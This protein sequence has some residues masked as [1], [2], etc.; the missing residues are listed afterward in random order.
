MQR[1]EIVGRQHG[2]D[3]GVRGIDEGGL[4]PDGD[5]FLEAPDF[6]LHVDRQKLLRG[7]ADAGALERL[8][9]LQS[10]AKCIPAW[11]DGREVVF[12]DRI[13]HGLPRRATRLVDELYGDAG[14]NGVRLADR[15]AHPRGEGL[16]RDGGRTEHAHRM[17]SSS[18]G[19][20]RCDVRLNSKVSSVD[21]LPYDGGIVSS[22]FRA[23]VRRRRPSLA[24]L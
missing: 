22:S 2:A 19:T 16:S 13:R 9:T 24:R 14:N 17:P 18:R 23:V 20:M 1:V 6:E 21:A 15:A 3:R 7:H 10:G 12:A 11:R 4:R 8:E 5:R